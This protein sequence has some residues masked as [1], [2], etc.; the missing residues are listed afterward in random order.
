METKKQAQELL[1]LMILPGFTVKDQKILTVN[2]AARRLFLEPGTEVLP[3]LV[4][5][6]EEY[7]AFAGGC[8][9]LTVSLAG[10]AQGVTVTRVG[11]TDVFLADQQTELRELQ[12]LSLAAQE[13]RMPLS[14]VILSADQLGAIQETQ[15]G[16]DSAARLNR[17]A[18]QLQRLICNMSDALRYTKGGR[19]QTRN[20]TA[21]TGE[22]TEKAAALSETAGI[23]LRF[24]RPQ[25]DI[26][27][28]LDS[29][30]LERAL[31][32][33]ISNSLKFTPKGGTVE[34]RLARSGKRILLTVQDNGSG[35]GD[36]ILK[37]VFS[38]YLRTPSLEDSRFGLGLGLTMVR[39]AAANHGGTVLI[40]RLDRGT[41]VTMTLALREN[42]E[43]MVR[44]PL[45]TVDYAGERDHGLLELSDALPYELYLPQEP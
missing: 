17:G 41:K 20:L 37:S 45:L 27:T 1:D 26:F 39:A 44:S 38:R 3:L 29:E 13:L 18:A 36:G 12:V 31:Y 43:T 10:E 21:L 9:Y 23:T 16:K 11:D 14:N 5:G 42:P 24:Q 40:D 4:T 8:L 15:E 35:I 32:N 25:E 7:E 2:D 19:L 28:L 22:I 34:V 30:Q 33:L 6:R